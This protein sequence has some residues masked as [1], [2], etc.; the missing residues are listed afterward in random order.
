VCERPSDDREPAPLDIR[1]ATRLGPLRLLTR[2]VNPSGF[3]CSGVSCSPVVSEWRKNPR[4]RARGSL[5]SIFKPPLSDVS[6]NFHRVTVASGGVKQKCAFVGDLCCV[7]C[8]LRGGRSLSLILPLALPPQAREKVIAK[9][10]HGRNVDARDIHVLRAPTTSDVAPFV[11]RR[12]NRTQ[13][14]LQIGR[15]RVTWFHIARTASPDLEVGPTYDGA[16]V[17]FGPAPA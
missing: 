10:H 3:S 5:A 7:I 12:L 1:P 6:A 14:R 17:K 15:L 4:R 16:G 9:L 11:G 2:T 13:D 8:A